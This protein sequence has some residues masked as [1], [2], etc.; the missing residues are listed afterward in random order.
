MDLPEIKNI[1]TTLSAIFALT[2]GIF[3]FA[4]AQFDSDPDKIPD[5]N[6]IYV[7]LMAVIVALQGFFSR[8]ARVSSEESGA[9]RRI[10]PRR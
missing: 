6:G 9:P 2:L 7:L 5:A 8:D 10:L 1:R 3:V 4:E